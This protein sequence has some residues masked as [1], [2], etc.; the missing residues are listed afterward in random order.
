VRAPLH[1]DAVLSV[2]LSVCHQN[3]C[4]EVQ[5]FSKTIQFRCMVSIDDQQEVPHG[6]FK[7]SI[8]RLLKFKMADIHYLENHQIA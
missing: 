7:E 1:V 8:F 5:F 6:L 3:P 2:R 4:T